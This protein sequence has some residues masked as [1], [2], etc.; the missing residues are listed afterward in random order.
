MRNPSLLVLVVAFVSLVAPETAVAGDPCPIGF[1]FYDPGPP[2]WLDRNELLDGLASK[3]TW[4]GLSFRSGADGVLVTNV[5]A[6]GPAAAAGILQG[7]VLTT[8]DGVA[9]KE[10]KV[11]AA[12]FRAKKPRDSIKIDVK[13]RD[14][15]ETVTVTLGA[16]DPLVGAFIDHASAQECS[17]VSRVDTSAD[18]AA[19]I[20][21]RIFS[22]TRRFECSAAHRKL[23]KLDFLEGSAIVVVRGS[24]R[25]LISKVGWATVCVAAAD[26]DGDKLTDAAVGKVFRKLT[27]A[28]VKDRHDNP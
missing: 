23:A 5:S 8:F 17:S 15:T 2:D 1:D 18:E 9:V 14:K 24:K 7:D 22:K 20:R 16:Q 11:A 19:Q 3:D 27:R 26:L 10:H 12:I 21:A 25:V 13:R 28:Y 6:T 4:V